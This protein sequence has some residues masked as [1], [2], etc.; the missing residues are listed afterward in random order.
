MRGTVR[1]AERDRREV[2]QEAQ[3]ARAVRAG[4]VDARQCSDY[5]WKVWNPRRPDLVVDFWPRSGK[6]GFHGEIQARSGMD[7]VRLTLPQLAERIR[8]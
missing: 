2:E 7:G 3:L 4:E 1:R 6:V 5:H 8:P